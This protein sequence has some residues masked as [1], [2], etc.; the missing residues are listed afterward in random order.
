M[1]EVLKTRGYIKRLANTIEINNL[2]KYIINSSWEF[3]IIYANSIG[4]KDIELG[5]NNF[6]K[7]EMQELT[8]SISD[9]II[10]DHFEFFDCSI[11]T[12]SQVLTT[13]IEKESL[14]CNSF[15]VLRIGEVFEHLDSDHSIFDFEKEVMKKQSLSGSKNKVGRPNRPSDSSIIKAHKVR[16]I[17]LSSSINIDDACKSVAIAKSTYYRVSKWIINNSVINN[18]PS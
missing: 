1:N 6:F 14:I 9:L 17:L 3:S 8:K 13:E 15:R 4:E 10:V 5:Y 2:F 16:K 12:Y 11:Y 18:F 7:K